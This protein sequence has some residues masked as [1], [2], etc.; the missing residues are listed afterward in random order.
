MDISKR[1]ILISI[2]LVMFMEAV[3]VTILNTSIPVIAKSLQIDPL[4]LKLAL[5]SYLMSMAVFIPISGW[6]ADKYGAYKVFVSSIIIFTLSSVACGYARNIEE[7]ILFRSLQGIGSSTTTPVGRLII[8]KIFP[9]HQMISVMS[10]V[11]I[12]ASLGNILGPLFGGIITTHFSW[13][14]IFWVNAP[15]GLLT[16]IISYYFLPKLAKS[17]VKKLDKL[18]FI[19]FGLGLASLNF[20]LSYLSEYHLP[21]G[22]AGMSI[23]ISIGLLSI[24]FIHSKRQRNPIVELKLFKIPSFRV[25]AICNLWFRIIMGG[26]PFVL[27]LLLQMNLKFSPE[28]AGA[29]MVPIALGVIIMKTWIQK[30]LIYFG[31]RKTL[32]TNTFFTSLILLSFILIE[33]SIKHFWIACMTFLYGF[34]LS[35]HY[36]SLNTLSYAKIANRD[37]SK[38]TSI[39]ST[40]QQLGISFGVATAA[41]ILRITAGH[42][43]VKTELSIENFHQC[44]AVLSLLNL[45]QLFFL[46]ELSSSDGEEFTKVK[47]QA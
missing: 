6:I 34:L 19:Y 46:R 20:G 40:I 11:V 44:F 16:F 18:G 9:K 32:I 22:L 31:N 47:H 2:A 7:L 12:I 5:I 24:Y 45:L 37:I 41:L 15:F 29:F 36:T 14:W 30:I 1:L 27:P 43:Q 28:L 35:L 39:I 38:A 17:H 26:I 3:D 10:M 13:P 42:F 25:A 21:H 33:P 23:L 4:D 8:L